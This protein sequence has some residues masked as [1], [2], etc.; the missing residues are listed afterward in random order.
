MSQEK[1][2]EENPN[3]TAH[4]KAWRWETAWIIKELQAFWKASEQGDKA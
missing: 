3:F 2:W 1:G 4:A